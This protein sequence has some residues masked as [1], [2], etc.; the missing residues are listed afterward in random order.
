MD[1]H[2][3]EV[4]ARGHR[5]AERYGDAGIDRRRP[6]TQPEGTCTGEAVAASLGL[7]EQGIR[8]N[9]VRRRNGRSHAEEQVFGAGG[10][11]GLKGQT[12]ATSSCEWTDCWH[13]RQTSMV[14]M[15]RV[16]LS[17]TSNDARATS[18]LT[19][20]DKSLPFDDKG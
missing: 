9:R 4:E 1:R 20:G 17:P 2:S 13:K 15:A 14:V 8:G 19:V 11:S 6:L 7:N 12:Q 3:E 18:L 10:L 16:L 5:D